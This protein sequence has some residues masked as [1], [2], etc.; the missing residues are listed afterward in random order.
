MRFIS[1]VF[2]IM[3]LF[4]LAACRPNAP[5]PTATEINH[6][7]AAATFEQNVENATTDTPA[8]TNNLRLLTNTPIV[9]AQAFPT[10]TERPSRTPEPTNTDRPTR[11][12]EPTDTERP[13][14][15]PLP[16]NTERPSNTPR[17]TEADTDTYYVTGS[18]ANVRSC[19]ETSCDR[20]TTL[21]YGDDIE[22]IER[23]DGA[24][25]AGSTRWYRVL[26]ADGREGFIHSSLVSTTRPVAGSSNNSGGSNSGSTGSTN[27]ASSSTNV[28][29]TE[30]PQQ[31]AQPTQ[32]PPPPP[33]P[34]GYSCDCNKTCGAM[35][36]EEAYYQLNTC[37][38][39]ARD[40]DNDGVPCES[41]C[42][43]G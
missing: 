28:Q 24:S 29:P 23:T 25:V 27:N 15:T 16:T 43:G 10:N 8:P 22:V 34:V 38:C 18:T 33:A 26:L 19:S 11:A 12:P 42:S 2:I 39:G 37:G 3:G 21:S 40:N 9:E 4:C 41:V 7:A 20:L 5:S 32:P 17:P 31:Q 30:V 1:I 36:C 14:H 35:T 6:T 13:S